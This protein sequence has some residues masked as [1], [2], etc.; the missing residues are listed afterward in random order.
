MLRSLIKKILLTGL[1]LTLMASTSI[2]SIPSTAEAYSP[3]TRSYS[4]DELWLLAR[5]VY[6]EA[7]G[8]PYLGKVAIA[9][10]VLNRVDSTLF[11]DTIAGVIY[12]PWQ[13]SCV[14]NWMFN[15][16][17][18]RDS[19]AAAREALNGHDPTGGALYYW[20]YHQ[21]TNPWLWSKPTATVI[22]NHWFAY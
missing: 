7:E 3:W 14:G 9:A 4:D 5:V 22:G 16:H 15:S 12:E 11:S 2:L 19:I 8:E 20:N 21:V 10:V 1:A 17:P 13:F 18:S 6:A